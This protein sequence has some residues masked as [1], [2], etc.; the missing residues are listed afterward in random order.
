MWVTQTMKELVKVGYLA[1][2][3]ER[4]GY[5]RIP[6]YFDGSSAFRNTVIRCPAFWSIFGTCVC[7]VEWNGQYR[8]T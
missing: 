2:N 4:I 1:T 6:S 7:S 5:S 3:N 8:S